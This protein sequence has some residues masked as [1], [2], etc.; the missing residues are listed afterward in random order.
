MNESDIR[1]IIEAALLAAGRSLTLAE[2]A[3]L[4]EEKGRPSP[5]ALRAE[6]GL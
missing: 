4:F 2:L 5:P 3:P 6:A 1:N